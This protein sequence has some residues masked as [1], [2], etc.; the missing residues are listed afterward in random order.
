MI[1]YKKALII[2]LAALPASNAQAMDQVFTFTRLNG[3][4]QTDM[5]AWVAESDKRIAAFCGASARAS[6]EVFANCPATCSSAV[7]DRP[8]AYPCADL[9]DSYTFVGVNSGVSYTCSWLT[10]S[11]KEATN[12]KRKAMYCTPE[13]QLTACAETCGVCAS[14]VTTPAPTSAPTSAPTGTVPTAT[15]SRPPSPMPSPFPTLRPTSTPSDAPSLVPSDAPSDSPSKVPSDEPSMLPSMEPSDSP[16]MVP[17]DVPSDS[18]SMVPSDEPSSLPSMQPSDQP[19]S[20]PSKEPSRSPSSMPSDQP[21]QVPSKEP[22]RS[23]STNP[24]SSI[25]PSPIPTAAPF[26][27]T[28]TPTKAPTKTPTTP[29]TACTDTDGFGW[30]RPTTDGATAREGCEFVCQNQNME[31]VNKRQ[32][33][34]CNDDSE[35]ASSIK[36]NCCYSCN[37]GAQCT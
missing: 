26:A 11:M 4:E 19:S 25:K 12:T 27:P 16:S 35:L 20:L 24:T 14:V 1:A 9:P 36:A 10:Q 28:T 17:S 6:G 21:S 22:S 15:P 29:P 7:A 34:W 18:P 13:Q 32:T 2:A 31:T 3:I 8:N 37:A 5:C 23:P 30:D 33:K